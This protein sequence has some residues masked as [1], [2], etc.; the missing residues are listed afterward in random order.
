MAIF[1]LYYNSYGRILSIELRAAHLSFVLGLIFLT[2]PAFKKNRKSMSSPS[3]ASI[4]L[5]LT[6]AYCSYHM[7]RMYQ[8]FANTGDLPSNFDLAVA[9]VGILVL[10]E[11]VRRATGWPLVVLAVIFILYAKY[12]NLAPGGFRIAPF[13]TFRILHQ[14]FYTENGIFGLVLGVS[15]TFIFLFILLGAFLGENKSSLLFNDISLAM[16]GKISGGPGLVAVIGSALMG[17]ISGSAV[18]NVAT[19]GAITIPLM[20]K[21]G[22][23]AEFAG[24]V[25]AVASSGGSIM[26]PVMASAAFIMAEMLGVQY[27]KII[28]AAF[29][30]AVL[31]YLALVA[32]LLLEARKH[33]MK[34]LPK[35][36][37]PALGAVLMARGHLLIPVA[38][39]MYLLISGRTPLFAGFW[40]VVLTVLVSWL[41]KDTRM[42]AA[43]II[44]ALRE[45]A[46]SSLVPAAACAVVGV[47]VGVA[48]MTGVGTM[49]AGNIVD[50]AR[51]NLAVALV[52]TM[53]ACLVLGMG[54]PTAACYI[55]AAVVAAPALIRLDVMP[56]AAHMFVL[57]YAILSNLTP[58]VAVASFTAAGIAEASP[59]KVALI[60]LRLGLAGFIVPIMF[61]YSPILLLQGDFTFL[62]AAQAI[63]TS[64][65]GV[66]CLGASL[67]RYV[68]TALN[69]FESAL[70]LVVAIL[71]IKPGLT[72]DLIGAGL[73]AVCVL[74]QLIKRSRK[75]KA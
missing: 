9:V 45:G 68:L 25:E 22:Y 62:E 71:L 51:G 65:I 15:A 24:A 7:F 66:C 60:G 32:M 72:T 35:E 12:G 30:P 38:A 17:T 69:L 47:I 26:P 4:A 14:L 75:A 55:T 8:F 42:S 36:D 13:S 37:L 41:R 53:I 63:L 20:K 21:V 6:G 46:L 74:S 5:A 10:F 19:T 59:N 50:A 39:V 57:Y 52:L 67:Q 16:A 2:F 56:V 33:G 64:L 28:L 23:R 29:I 11:A 1:H 49:V 18:A 3:L 43:A 54:L 58:P 70:L 34:G 73:L 48:S 27:T 31:Y 44:R 61:C 40:G